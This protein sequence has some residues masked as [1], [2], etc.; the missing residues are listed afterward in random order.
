MNFNRLRNRQ[1]DWQPIHGQAHDLGKN[2]QATV[3]PE[4]RMSKLLVAILLITHQ[5]VAVVPSAA[6]L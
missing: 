6:V 4:L 2:R 3:P 1:N 5:S